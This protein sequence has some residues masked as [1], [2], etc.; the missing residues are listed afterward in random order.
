MVRQIGELNRSNHLVKG[1]YFLNLPAE[2]LSPT[3][4]VEFSEPCT[5][6]KRAETLERMA[7]SGNKDKLR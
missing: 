4:P 5:H 1:S 7:N 6:I 2:P 3:E